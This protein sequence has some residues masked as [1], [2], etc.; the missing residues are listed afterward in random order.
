MSAPASLQALLD[1][2]AIRDCLYRYC[3]GIDRCDEAALRS[4]YWEDATDCHGAW[5]GSASGFIDQ[6]LAKLRQGGRRVHQITNVLIELH[7]D[8]AAVESSFFALQTMAAQPAQQTF[9][10]GRYV[11]RFERRAGQWRVAARTV[12]YD[13]IEERARP[14]LARDDPTLFGPR[15]PNGVAAPDDMVYRL[16]ESIRL[17]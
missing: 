5:N 1:R 6:A 9:L 11:D 12:V 17:G 13:W 7:G 8:A 16:L 10:C 4:A 14:E 3:R 2:E 15:Q